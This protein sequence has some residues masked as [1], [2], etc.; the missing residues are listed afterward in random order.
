M[1]RMASREDLLDALLAP[2]PQCE[3]IGRQLVAGLSGKNGG[4][5]PYASVWCP[6]CMWIDPAVSA[7]FESRLDSRK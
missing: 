1:P 5:D 2:C 7:E 4:P 3:W 6:N